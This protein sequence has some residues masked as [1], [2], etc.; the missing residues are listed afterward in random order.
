MSVDA[1]SVIAKRVADFLNIMSKRL[2]D[3]VFD[4]LCD[5]RERE[6]SEIARS[7]YDCMFE[8]IYEAIRLDRP[9]C[10]DTGL[11]QFFVKVGA[12]FPYLSE[13]SG[14][15]RDATEIATLETPLRPNAVEPFIEKN[16][17]N[18]IAIGSPW[19]EWEIV[20]ENDELCLEVYMAGGGCSLPGKSLVL[21]PSAGY[22]GIAEVVLD[23][24][25]ERGINACPP[26]LVGIG[27]GTCADSA[28]ILSKKALLRK[29]GSRN[30]LPQAAHLE[31]LLKDAINNIGIG[32][33]ALTGNETVIDVH[34]EYAA[35]HPATLA[36][37]VSF[38][39]WATRRGCIVFDKDLNFKILSHEKTLNLR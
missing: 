3:D 23:A 21:M 8:N 6:S 32:P 14:A 27:I 7:V 39:C 16:T 22:E 38:G 4:C 18:N 5:M 9:I 36:V 11:I 28:G 10:Q 12:N 33:N 35:H 29:I 19:I 31:D 13:I 24:V 25:C 37:G 30:P 15:L 1:A 2:P 20:P 34:V 17:G 26:L